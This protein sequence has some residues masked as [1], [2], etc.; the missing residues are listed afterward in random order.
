MSKG[1][2][3]IERA[4][5]ALFDA[6]PDL[7]FVT[8]EL[9]EHCYPET[10]P[11]ERRHQVSVL[12]AAHKI[13]AH[14]P[15]WTA[16]RINGQGKGWVFANHANLSSY[17]LA[18]VIAGQSNVYRSEKRAR[19]AV[20]YD[21]FLLINGA[22]VQPGARSNIE[23]V[24]PSATLRIGWVR[25]KHRRQV[26]SSRWRRSWRR[27]NSPRS[28][29]VMSGCAICS[30]AIQRRRCPNGRACRTSAAAAPSRSRSRKCCST[31]ATQARGVSVWTRTCWTCSGG[32]ELRKRCCIV[33][34]RHGSAIQC[35]LSLAKRAQ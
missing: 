17:A 25:G 7:A 26:G 19:R 5:R 35:R 10:R 24:S 12:R 30:A 16:W 32:G 13:V 27:P 14:D 8:D 22:R 29:A 23:M 28:C 31:R 15:N 1:P 20:G 9:A 21:D 4:I 6:H 2:G 3:R 33:H 11:I 18:R 34:V